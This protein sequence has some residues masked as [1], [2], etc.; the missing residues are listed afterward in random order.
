MSRKKHEL[1]KKK[2]SELADSEGKVVELNKNN[3]IST[4]INST[5]ETA[6][7]QGNT[8]QDDLK[9]RHFA[10]V[11]YPESAPED[12]IEQMQDTGLAFVISPLHDKDTNPD[13]TPK[14]PHYHMIVSWGNTTTY[15]SAKGLCEM[16]NCPIPQVLRNCTGMYRYLTHKDNPEKYQYTE[17]PKTYNGWVR[18]LDKAD[19][20]NLKAE[21]WS[22]VYINDCREYGELLMV[23]S[24]KGS[25][26]FEVAS[27]NTVFFK[28]VCDG[29]R[30][31]PTR[32]LQRRYATITDEE[33]KAIIRE[34]LGITEEVDLETG[35]IA[36][37]ETD[38][39]QESE[40]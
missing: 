14:K 17:I 5:T 16:L 40:N 7:N 33:E 15:K 32:T 19:V 31:N 34:R 29:F 4:Y 25:E 24:S 18:P 8:K 37:E 23:C 11:V 12:W 21:I 30:H 13:N 3:D 36:E 28:A 20:S 27:N 38:N 39:K 2:P 1:A 22:M 10:Y 9:G 26:Y 35:E 6:E